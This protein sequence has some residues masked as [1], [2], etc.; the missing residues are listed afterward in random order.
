MADTETEWMGFEIENC[1][2]FEIKHGS[3][4]MVASA[5]ILAALAYQG[6]F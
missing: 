1:C 2:Q 6:E 5:N 4:N 3:F